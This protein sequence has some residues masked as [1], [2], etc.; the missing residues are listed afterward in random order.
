MGGGPWGRVPQGPRTNQSLMKMKLWD[1][2]QI[3]LCLIPFIP[4]LWLLEPSRLGRALSPS[5]WGHLGGLLV[6][7]QPCPRTEGLQEP[8]GVCKGGT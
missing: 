5:S 8:P 7:G 2:A 1:E 6:T 4:E 3:W